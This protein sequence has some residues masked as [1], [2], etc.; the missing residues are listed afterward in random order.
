MYAALDDEV[1]LPAYTEVDAA[2]F[3]RLPGNLRAQ[4]NIENLFDIRYYPTAH[5]NNN[6]SPGSPRAMRVS[7]RASF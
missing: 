4:A 1:T 6:I 5:S 2:L 3:V 7:L